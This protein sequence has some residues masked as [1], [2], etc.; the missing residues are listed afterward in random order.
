MEEARE[1][2]RAGRKSQAEAICRKVI[3]QTP[4][5]DAAWQLLGV[6]ALE[7]KREP[8]AVQLFMRALD[9]APQKPGYYVNFA[10]GLHRLGKL[11][12]AVDALRMAI[13]LDPNLAEAHF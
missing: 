13:S 5:N 6:M 4:R 11:P 2:F 8:L 7:V 9:I 12:E 10:V 1:H 3:A